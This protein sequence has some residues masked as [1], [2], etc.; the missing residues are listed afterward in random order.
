M[1]TK[2]LE[3]TP[4]DETEKYNAAVADF[5]ATEAELEKAMEIWEE[6]ELELDELTSNN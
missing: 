1:K 5:N 2:V 4:Y 6:S 3:E